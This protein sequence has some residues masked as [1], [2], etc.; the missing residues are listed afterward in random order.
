M[1][2]LNSPTVQAMLGN[3]PQGYGNMPVYYGSSPTVTQPNNGVQTPFPSPKEMITQGGQ[4][5]IYNPTSF[6]PQNIIGGYN[7]GFNAAFAGYSNPY[8]NYGNY[9]LLNYYQSPPDADSRDRLEVAI[10]NGLSYDEQLEEESKLYKTMS[11]IVSKNLGRDTKETEECE[12]AFN[13][14]NKYPQKHNSNDTTIKFLHVKLIVGD[15]VVADIDPSSL[16]NSEKKFRNYTGNANLVDR[17]KEI[18]I[19]NDCEK[20]RRHSMI[21]NMALERQFDNVEL[22]DFFNNC[23]NILMSDLMIRKAYEQSLGR[24]SSIYDRNEFRKRLLANNNIR[25]RDQI[26]AME[27]FASRY[28]VMPDGRP[29]SPGHDPEIASS[30]SYNE[31]TGQYD[32]IAPN[33]IRDR[34]ERA[35][36]TFIQSIDG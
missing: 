34:M 1:L 10:L 5:M 20:A 11:R 36:Q 2:N 9:N 17:M 14:Y 25:S 29:V 22:L 8:M 6:A 30:F 3:T 18:K 33:F 35:R 27:R 7:P 26:N 15:E 13:I 31:K 12:K 19:Q 24:T 21:Y 23:A 28:G 4:Q 16:E 32:V